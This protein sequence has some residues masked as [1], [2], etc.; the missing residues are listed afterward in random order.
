MPVWLKFV[1]HFCLLFVIL[2]WL[3][4]YVG[5]VVES[6]RHL[7]FTEPLTATQ[8]AGAI[9]VL[10]VALLAETLFILEDLQIVL[11]P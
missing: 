10:A 11:V 6:R 5:H 3:K 1:V 8:H 4:L 2:A 7:S 9:T